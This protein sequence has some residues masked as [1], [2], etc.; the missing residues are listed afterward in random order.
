LGTAL[1]WIDFAPQI[2]KKVSSRGVF[3]SNQKFNKCPPAALVSRRT[4]PRINRIRM[5]TGG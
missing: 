1:R 2:L 3:D 5:A 4:G